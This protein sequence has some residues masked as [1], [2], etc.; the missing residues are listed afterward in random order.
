MKI[1][2]LRRVFGLQAVEDASGE[3]LLR[4]RDAG[5]DAAPAEEY[6]GVRTQFVEA[7]DERLV[8]L[9]LQF[10][11]HVPVAIDDVEGGI[12][13]GKKLGHGGFHLAET[14]EA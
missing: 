13:L 14:R 6:R 8:A 1:R 7:P 9:R 2:P 11:L 5:L 12:D 4:A 3:N 10:R